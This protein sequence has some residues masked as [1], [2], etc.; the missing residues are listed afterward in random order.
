LLKNFNNEFLNINKY[1]NLNN[2]KNIEALK[3]EKSI[4][5][6]NVKFNFLKKKNYQEQFKISNLDFEIKKNS[7]T[8][9]A[10]K[11]GSGKT[12]LI[13]ILSGIFKPDEGFLYLDDV[14]I[15]EENLHQYRKNISYISQNIFLGS[16]TVKDIIQFGSI[17]KKD[18]K[19]KLE[20]VTKKAEIFD[21]IDNLPNKF[22]T[23]VG[24]GGVDFSSGQKQRILLS[25]FFYLNSKILILDEA[26]NL[27]DFK[28]EDTLINNLINDKENKTIIVVTHGI[29]N[30]K[31]F[32]NILFVEDG[33]LIAQGKYEVLK[34]NSS[35]FSEF[36]EKYGE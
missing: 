11:T 19:A 3:F 5:L 35:K 20:F 10:G 30:L 4:K 14:I 29:Q 22:D 15:N 31:K 23:F 7:I 32:D 27:L 17:V 34:K 2:K 9:I 33:N 24:D 26:T 36:V 8:G 25:R 6:K 1:K 21:F 28:T 16:G 12:T 13:D 18:E